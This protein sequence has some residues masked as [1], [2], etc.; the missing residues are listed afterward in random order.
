MLPVW[1]KFFLIYALKLNIGRKIMARPNL[2]APNDKKAKLRLK[3]II[4]LG[5]GK[6]ALT[7]FADLKRA[8]QCGDDD[9]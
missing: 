3:C 7:T 9:D 5:G 2:A 4:F 6:S 1:A 8:A